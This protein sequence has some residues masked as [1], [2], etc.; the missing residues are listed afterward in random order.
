MQSR[1]ARGPATN[2]SKKLKDT[3]H[4]SMLAEKKIRRRS[5][6]SDKDLTHHARSGHA[7]ESREASVTRF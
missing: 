1:Y 5:A 4:S 6:D 3:K 2:K 7:V